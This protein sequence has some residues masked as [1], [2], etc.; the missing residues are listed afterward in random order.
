VNL[1]L[2][3][4]PRYYQSMVPLLRQDNRL[5]ESVV[6]HMSCHD[7]MAQVLVAHGRHGVF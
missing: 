3:Q 4:V 5:N 1:Q 6:R 7:Q 2:Q